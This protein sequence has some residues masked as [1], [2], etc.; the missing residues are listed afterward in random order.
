MLAVVSPVL[1][2]IYRYFHVF[3][4]SP[5]LKL[6]LHRSFDVLNVCKSI[7]N[8]PKSKIVASDSILNSDVMKSGPGEIFGTSL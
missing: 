5:P 8:V 6:L 1:K 2:Y 4:G 7:I 3:T